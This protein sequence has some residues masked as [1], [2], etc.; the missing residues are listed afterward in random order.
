MDYSYENIYGRDYAVSDANDFY[1]H[2]IEYVIPASKSFHDEYMANYNLLTNEETKQLRSFINSNGFLNNFSYIESYRDFMGGDFKEAFDNLFNING[3]NYYISHEENC[4]EGAYMTILGEQDNRYPMVYYGGSYYQSCQ[5]IVHEFGHYFEAIINGEHDLSYDLAESQSQGDEFLF[6]EYLA[7]N[8]FAN[9]G[10]VTP[11]GKAIINH[12]LSD[13]CSL[14]VLASLVDHIEKLCYEAE[15][16]KVGDLKQF[17]LDEYEAH[18]ALSTIY[19]SGLVV[20]YIQDVSMMSPCYYISY[21]TSLIPSIN[22]N[23]IAEDDLNKGKESYLK[24][25]NH[26]GKEDFIEVCEYA[27]LYNPFEE[28]TFISLFSF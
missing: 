7:Q 8:N 19:P 4:Y 17:V 5:T 1:N 10:Q 22:I 12:Y 28:E 18:P 20:D 11:L 14:I 24:L 25:I 23:M 6:F 13:A 27:G 2:V 15:E 26:P 16:L 9:N 3:G 21:A